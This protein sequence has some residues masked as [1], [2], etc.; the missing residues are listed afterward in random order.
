MY[1]I[2]EEHIDFILGDL[3]ARGIR[4]PDLLQ[5]LLDHICILIERN[6]NVGDNF[7]AYYEDI[8][9]RFYSDELAEIETEARFLLRH[10]RPLLLLSRNQFLAFLFLLLPGPFIGFVLLWFVRVGP[11]HGYHIPLDI[12]GG[13][14]VFSLFPSLIWLVLAFTPDRFDPLLPKRAKVLLG[15]RPLISIL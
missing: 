3:K 15:W 7:M 9:P 4:T 14:M 6:L 10:R 12:W 5:N 11:M 2:T 1:P 8:L 13:A